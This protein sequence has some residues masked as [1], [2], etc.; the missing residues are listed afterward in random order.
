MA[1]DER[2]LTAERGAVYGHP[3]DDFGRVALIKQAVAECPDPEVRHAL[4]MIGVKLARLV[5]TPD[6][7]DT[8][9]DIKG[10][11]ECINM[12]HAERRLRGQKK[13]FVKTGLPAPSWRSY[14]IP[15]LGDTPLGEGDDE[16]PV[17]ARC[18]SPDHHVSDCPDIGMHEGIPEPKCMQRKAETLPDGVK[19]WCCDLCHKSGVGVPMS[20]PC[21]KGRE[22]G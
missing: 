7:Q 2:E 11:A 14:P 13:S 18:H 1:R 17:C 12:I 8:I 19:T 22:Q 21:L 6:H 3:L 10:Y 15:S 20:T 9:D 16:E 5:T 4:E